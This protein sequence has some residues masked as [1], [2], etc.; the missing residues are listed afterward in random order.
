MNVI[1]NEH[2]DFE[3]S[4][5]SKSKP[6]PPNFYPPIFSPFLLSLK[7]SLPLLQIVQMVPDSNHEDS[8]SFHSSDNNDDDDDYEEKD[9]NCDGNSYVRCVKLKPKKARHQ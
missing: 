7:P 4:K 6:K 8:I 5:M 9:V 3:N 2:S 1:Q